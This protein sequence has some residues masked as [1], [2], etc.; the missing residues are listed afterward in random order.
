MGQ[1]QTPLQLRQTVQ[2]PVQK[3]E[4]DNILWQRK[5]TTPFSMPKS[6]NTLQLIKVEV[7]G[8]ACRKTAL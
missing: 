8:C 3:I 6:R 7:Q 5:I 1:Y 4:I 2:V